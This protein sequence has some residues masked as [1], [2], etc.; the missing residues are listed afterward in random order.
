MSGR[1]LRVLIAQDCSAWSSYFDA[2]V[3]M[4]EQAVAAANTSPAG[5]RDALLARLDRV[6]SRSHKCGYGIG[7][8][9]DSILAKHTKRKNRPSQR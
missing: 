8:D 4:F 9:M 1:S 2:L 6:R 7:D 3:R 5:T